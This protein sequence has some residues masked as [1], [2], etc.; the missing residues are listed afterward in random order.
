MRNALWATALLFGSGVWAQPVLRTDNLQPPRDYRAAPVRTVQAS[1]FE[2]VPWQDLGDGM[3]RKVLFSDRLT[4]VLLE[5]D[6]P[7]DDKPAQPH[8]HS[9]DQITYLLEGRGRVML[10]GQEREISA[11]GAYTVPS[12]TP[13]ALQPLTPRL[14]LVEC[15]TP[16]REDFRPG[17][18]DN[19]LRAFVYQWFALFDAN[20]ADEAFL[21]H[22]DSERMEM[23]FPE[24][25]LHTPAE[26][27][28]WRRG[29]LQRFPSAS[30]DIRDL[31]VE[32]L[33]PTLFKVR[34]RV[35]W[36]PA[37][38]PTSWYRQEWEV[39]TQSGTP[40]ILRYL[41]TSQ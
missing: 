25:T 5:I 23:R 30:H 20:A 37:G 17:F 21:E 41:V 19:D 13:H 15:F 12:N 3:R 33:G 9:H 28:A 29:V 10:D 39:D 34:L 1:L 2:Q 8:Y 27:R 35:G 31:E 18:G 40:R 11:G 26:F 14:V 32:R 16:T 22:L 6:R 38:Q 24:A 7:V 36:T 4:L